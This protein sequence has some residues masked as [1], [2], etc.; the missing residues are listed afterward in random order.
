MLRDLSGLPAGA[1]WDQQR[2]VWLAQWGS[3]ES[4]QPCLEQG[5]LVLWGEG[6]VRNPSR[7]KLLLGICQSCLYEGGDAKY[8]FEQYRREQQRR[9]QMEQDNQTLLRE[10]HHRVKNNLQVICSLLRLQSY[11]YS[12]ADVIAGF[13]DMLNR[14]QAMASLHERLYR[15]ASP[16]VVSV[17][18]YIGGLVSTIEQLYHEQIESRDL[19][20]RLEISLEDLTSDLAIS[21]GLIVHELLT[22]ALKHAFP[23][24]P[25]LSLP[26]PHRVT[27]QIAAPNGSSIFIIVADNGVGLPAD[28][29]FQ[30][31]D[32]IGLQLVYDLVDQLGGSITVSRERGTLFHISLPIPD[33]IAD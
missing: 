21:C 11:R 9:Q 29:E 5:F 8:W 33:P 1:V 23:A 13:E 19:Q 30:S 25:A 15:S 22:N 4:L 26:L 20:I 18:E 14:I 16:S 10:V 2:Q 24:D 3:R 17:Q 27:I 31:L 6:K 12:D 7:V 28:I 32:S